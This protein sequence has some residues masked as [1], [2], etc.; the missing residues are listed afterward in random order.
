MYAIIETGGKQYKVEAG[1]VVFVEKLNAEAD[2]EVIFDK[3]IALG[4]DDGIKVGAPYVDGATVADILGVNAKAETADGYLHFSFSGSK[5][6]A[7]VIRGLRLHLEQLAG[8]YPA[9]VKVTT[10]E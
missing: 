7:D 8:D 2:S 1:D 5:A 3:V 10:E 9:K 4:A 6:A